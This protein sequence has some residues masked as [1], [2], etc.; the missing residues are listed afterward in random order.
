MTTCIVCLNVG[1]TLFEVSKSTC[2]RS[3]SFFSPLVLNANETRATFFIDRDPTHFRH[4][5][6]YMRGTPTFPIHRH[7]LEE[8]E[9]EADFYSLPAFSMLIKER[10]ADAKH[11]N[12]AYW[13]S[14]I[15]EKM[16]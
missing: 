14:V 6:N 5:L 10:M 8:L 3:A 11:A 9:M 1:G 4:I 15:A 16:G 7:E 13:L 12:A 2:E